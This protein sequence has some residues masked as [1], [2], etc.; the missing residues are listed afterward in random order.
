MR[1]Y[2][3]ALWKAYFE[4]GYSVLS[5]PKWVIGVFGVGE[6][7]NK[8]YLMVLF[9]AFLFFL[10]CIIVGL[11]WYKKGIAQAEAEVGNQYNL[12]VKQMRRKIYK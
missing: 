11:I 3:F 8:N 9:G 4:K 10:L 5:Y 7:V 2:K 1:F 6:V 12:F